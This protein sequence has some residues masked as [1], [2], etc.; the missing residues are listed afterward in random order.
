MKSTAHQLTEFFEGFIWQDIVDELETWR[1]D[2][3]ET[4]EKETD[5]AL[6]NIL[7]GNSV[8]IRRVI[9]ELPHTLIGLAMEE[10]EDREQS[11]KGQ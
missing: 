4:W 10:I 1:K 9:E 7:K 8:A 6:S 2:I 5:T 11:R 3:F